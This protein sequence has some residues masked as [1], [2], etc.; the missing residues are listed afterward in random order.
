MLPRYDYLTIYDGPDRSHPQVGRYCGADLPP[1]FTSSLLGVVV[2]FHSDSSDTRG[3]FEIEFH[4]IGDFED[5][6]DEELGGDGGD[7]VESVGGDLGVGSNPG[8]D[9]G[10]DGGSGAAVVE[11]STAVQNADPAVSPAVNTDGTE[12]TVEVDGK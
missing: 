12:Q 8:S 11:S 7:G 9:G 6:G 2:E 10:L 3:G 4:G 1:D 5:I